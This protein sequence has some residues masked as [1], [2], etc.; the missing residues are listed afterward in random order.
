MLSFR[1]FSSVGLLLVAALPAFAGPITYVSVVNIGGTLFRD[2]RPSCSDG[3]AVRGR[4]D[5][6]NA[7]IAFE[8]CGFGFGSGVA[9]SEEGFLSVQ[10]HLGSEDVE[11]AAKATYFDPLPG[12]ES[13]LI[14]YL[15]A[16]GGTGVLDPVFISFSGINLRPVVGEGGSVIVSGVRNPVLEV[17]GTLTQGSLDLF[18]TATAIPGTRFISSTPEPASLFLLLLPVVW[19]LRRVAS[20]ATA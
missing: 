16:G 11:G 20:R 7:N 1:L 2:L 3:G 13:F 19:I 10:I 9:H 5:A 14:E 12:K 8:S 6:E 15:W 4:S 18:A 17:S